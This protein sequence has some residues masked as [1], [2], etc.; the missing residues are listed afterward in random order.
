MSTAGLAMS[1]YNGAATIDEALASVAAQSRL[2]DQIVIVDDGSTDDTAER[3]SGWAG[4][5]PITLIRQANQGVAAGRTAAIGGLATDLVLAL[6]ADDV[7]LPAHVERLVDAHDRH[8][9]LVT[10]L[11]LRWHPGRGPGPLVARPGA[12]IESVLTMN[13][14]FAG[15]LFERAAFEAAGGTYRFDG[16]EDWDLWLRLLR[17]GVGVSALEEP[18]VHYRVGGDSLSADD[19]TL[20]VECEVLEA[21]IDETDDAHLRDVARRSLRH[22]HARLA[23]R[24]SYRQAADGHPWAARRSA[25]QAFG[26]PANVRA[27]GLAMTVAPGFAHGRREAIRGRR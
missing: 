22:R 21:F 14:V 16:C 12:G 11:A 24:E 1:V 10:P 18:T 13:W 25:L 2:P 17:D 9:G 20:P 4:R 6:D 3:V 27:L 23:L 7:W 5:L 15:S 19:R 26:G 8:G